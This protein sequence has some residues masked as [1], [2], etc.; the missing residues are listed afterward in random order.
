MLWRYLALRKGDDFSPGY[1]R[2]RALAIAW[3]LR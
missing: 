1:S 3:E 2:L